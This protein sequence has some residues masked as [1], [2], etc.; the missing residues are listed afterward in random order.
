MILELFK[1]T[2]RDLK[3]FIALATVWP[4]NFL[5]VLMVRLNFRAGMTR[6]FKVRLKLFDWACQI[7]DWAGVRFSAYQRCSELFGLVVARTDDKVPVTY[8]IKEAETHAEFLSRQIKVMGIGA[9]KNNSDLPP[10]LGEYG[11]HLRDRNASPE[12]RVNR[13]VE[14]LR[15][16]GLG[17][18]IK[19]A[20][21]YL[22]P[23]QVAAKLKEV[24]EQTEKD[25]GV[26]RGSIAH[27]WAEERAGRGEPDKPIS[28]WLD[29]HAAIIKGA[30]ADKE[31]L[32][33]PA[34]LGSLF[35]G[36]R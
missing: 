21:M 13:L 4:L 27:A 20:A 14:I 19:G 28:K 8:E 3:V 9:G 2:R 32:F 26:P 16:G 10:N 24:M 18:Q 33:S 1:R 5:V 35:A 30:H 34:G 11:K 25:A 23:Q 17:E 31:R 12:N 29:E 15:S 6:Q 22:T 7:E 36:L